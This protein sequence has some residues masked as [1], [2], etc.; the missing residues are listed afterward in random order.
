[1]KKYICNIFFFLICFSFTHSLLSQKSDNW[2]VTDVDG[3]EHNLYEDYLNQGEV[4]V[5]KFFWVDC[6]PCNSIAPF[7]Q[8]L[9]V[10]LG[11][12]NEGVQFFDFTI[13]GGDTDPAVRGFKN[14]HGLTFPSVSSDGGSLDVVRPYSAGDFGDALFTPSFAVIAPDG[15]VTFRVPGNGTIALDNIKT[16]VEEAMDSGGSL[17]SV[18]NLGAK[19]AFGQNISGVTAVLKNNPDNSIS[20]PIDLSGPLTITSLADDF[21]G[22]TNPVISFEKKDDIKRNITPLDLLLIRKHIL[23]IIPITDPNMLMAADTNGDGTITP[24][25][26]LVLQKVILAIFDSFPIDSY[27]FS[28]AEIPLSLLPGETQDFEV[29]GV[30]IGDLNGF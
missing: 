26:M 15:E 4:V 30:K 27:I 29:T 10:E 2:I 21:P 14:Q 24:L 23:N 18:F 11:E 16:L 19:D 7:V 8:E 25:D 22:I 20:Y 17:P 12:G 13:L 5:L 6:P 9:Y 28:P 3:N 1:M